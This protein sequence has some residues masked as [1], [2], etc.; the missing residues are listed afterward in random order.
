MKKNSLLKAI[1]ISF[2]VVVFLSWVIPAGNYASVEFSKG[3]I[4]PI[5]LLD[6]IIYPIQAF[7][8][9][10]QYGLLFI[11]IGGF[12]GIL[13]RTGVYSK[14][15]NKI[16]NTFRDNE[17]LL[18]VVIAAFLT[19]LSSLTGMSLGLFVL[20]PFLAT[21]IHLL[22]YKK[23]TA[24]IA[25]VGAILTGA[26][27]SISSAD[28]NN[29][30]VYFIGANSVNNILWIKIVLFVLVT[31]ALIGYLW[32]FGSK[33][34]EKEEE[35]TTTKKRATKKEEAVSKPKAK[36]ILF[37]N[38]EV[39]DK[40]F[41]PLVIT[42][43]IILIISIIG[44]F[45]WYYVFNTEFFSEL[46][47]T[48]SN[49]EISG[50]PLFKNLLGTLSPIGTWDTFELIMLLVLGSGL[51]GWLYSLKFKTMMEAFIDGA[52]EMLPTA[53]YVTLA[54]VV[55]TVMISNTG[56]SYFE[57]P[58]YTIMDKIVGKGGNTNFLSLIKMIGVA[59]VGSLYFNN[60]LHLFGNSFGILSEFYTD[61]TFYPVM[62]LIFQTINSILMMVLPTSLVLVGGLSYFEI[63]YK[64]WLKN[65]WKYLLVILGVVIIMTLIT[66]MFLQ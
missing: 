16:V 43:A 13:N 9:F 47:T 49:F 46:H 37:S 12:Y 42:V 6:L 45:K 30:Y 40:S 54:N 29:I 14:L 1:A 3:E 20:V 51:V 39:E 31:G 34:V 15:V 22:G 25:T 7:N 66:F 27:G 5:G 21:I 18:L 23:I 41:M 62:G 10:G 58:Y 28:I 24:M 11:V 33:A 61:A 35:P 19:L 26:V 4:I 63:S 48:I 8:M 57:T 50:Y 55:F 2:L 38:Y 65:S 44:M 59:G 64:D 52:K 36:T 17:K 32:F 56:S 53:I 60:I